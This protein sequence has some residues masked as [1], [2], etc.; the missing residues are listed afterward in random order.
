MAESAHGSS[1]A[2]G[3]GGEVV[4]ALNEMQSAAAAADT[5]LTDNGRSDNGEGSGELAA[6]SGR[7]APQVKAHAADMRRRA[8]DQEA[9]LHASIEKFRQEMT[10]QIQAATARL[11]PLRE[12]VARLEET[13]WTVNLYLGR[14]EEIITLTDGDPAPA[15]TPIT[16]RQLV[17]SMDQE[18]LVAATSGGI[19][20]RN[21]EEFDTWVSSAPEHL[22]QVLPEP[23]GVVVLVPRR[24][25]RDYG[26]P[27][28]QKAMD[29]AN[30][31]SYWLIRNGDRLY[32][33]VTDFTVG[34]RLVPARD[35]FLS[36][37]TTRSFTGAEPRQLQPGTGEWLRA[38][39]AANA[40]QRHFMRAA[41]ILQG[42]IDRTVV[43]HPLPVPTVSVLSE[44]SY[45]AGHVRTVNDAEATL[46]TG[47]EPFKVWL[48]RLNR[49]LR[50]GMRVVG[51]FNT[52]RFRAL[53]PDWKHR[54]NAHSRITP[55]GAGWPDT[56]TLYTI[57]RDRDGELRFLYDRPDQIWVPGEGPRPAARRAS[58]RISP[59]DT[60]IIP[61]DLVTAEECAVYMGARTERHAYVDMMPLLQ[62]VI[63]TKHAE[64]EAEAPFC[65]LLAG[66]LTNTFPE[67]DLAQARR[68]VPD[69][70]RWWKLKNRI[71]RPLVNPDDPKVEAA[72]ITAI[73][74][75]Q[76]ARLADRRRALTDPEAEAVMVARLRSQIP[77]AMMVAR[78]RQGGYVALEPQP[79]T[80]PPGA[81]PANVW[82]REHSTGAT[83]V[84]IRARDWVMPRSRHTWRI[85]WHAPAWERW[86]LDALSRDHFTDPELAEFTRQAIAVSGDR[87]RES[88]YQGRPR[89]PG[90]VLAAAFNAAARQ[91]IVWRLEPTALES[92]DRPLTGP[93]PRLSITEV[94]FTC[95]R[96]TAGAPALIPVRWPGTRD[97]TVPTTP[98]KLPAP[99]W[100]PQQLVHTDDDVLADL[101]G[102][103]VA[104][105]RSR[106]AAARMR[107]TALDAI[108]SVRAAWEAAAEADAFRRFMDDYDDEARWEGHRKTLNLRW[109][110]NTHGEA[111]QTLIFR[112]VETGIDVDGMRVG[113]AAAALTGRTGDTHAV[114]DD[115]ADL[116]ITI[117]GECSK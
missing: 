40:R 28:L 56:G 88:G 16:V 110:H 81:A 116:V 18:C 44:E 114:P 98:G 10:A 39:K 80:L 1:P 66:E 36:F 33:M 9:A 11:A 3:P 59:D 58:C 60:W 117:P 83:G 31:Q 12:Q 100:D 104:Y 4:A 96:T 73:V 49:R 97:M 5:A 84:T 82:V 26:D 47:R 13:I 109:P 63:D 102:L 92:S 41:L 71:H 105:S 29:E 61:V 90:D 62:T 113:A 51:A 67:L 24:T 85:L 86:D 108:A 78:T 55:E 64:A 42:L 75:E 72:A 17:L 77:G 91:L 103:T 46:G 35:E 54:Y 45:T 2:D 50:P 89:D 14:D 74:A 111:V 95:S 38:E 94:P 106:D 68:D 15:D 20:V 115:V 27:W 65:E 69:L 79:R 76:Q 52:E 93:S 101:H 37:F 57:E 107:R 22:E 99:P 53:A 34:E 30:H 19:D 23:R 21:L 7:A 43:F 25:P 112:A 6:V 8:L 87:V 48:Q 70:V 32:R